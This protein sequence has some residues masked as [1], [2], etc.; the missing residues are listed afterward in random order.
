M[1]KVA[2]RENRSY[3]MSDYYDY[4]EYD[5]SYYKIHLNNLLQKNRSSKK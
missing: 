3:I 4:D 2:T 5:S 1:K